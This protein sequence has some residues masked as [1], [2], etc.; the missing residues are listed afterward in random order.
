[1]K[2]ESPVQKKETMEGGFETVENRQEAVEKIRKVISQR[3]EERFGEGGEDEMDFHIPQH[4][5]DVATDTSVFL[6]L[7]REIDPDLVSE[8]DIDLGMLEGLGHDLLQNADKDPGKM[9]RRHRGFEP[10]DVDEDFQKRG[11]VGNERR[12]AN[13][14]IKI[15]KK[16]KYP[17]GSDVFPTDKDEISADIGVTFPWMDFN[18][19]FPEQDDTPVEKR[20]KGLKISQPYLT[21]KSSLRG[22]ALATADL[23][24]DFRFSDDLSVFRKAGKAEYRELKIPIR[25]AI[26]KG[27]ENI[28]PE[29]RAEITKDL[30]SWEASQVGFARWQQILFEKSIEENEM[31]NSSPKAEEIKKVLYK[32]YGK[33]EVN[34]KGADRYYKRLKKEFGKLADA[35][36]QKQLADE[37]GAS[38]RELLREMGYNEV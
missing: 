24:G 2:F 31:L 6:K 34:I 3:L 18:E 33:F 20:K 35:K 5:Y 10:K 22:L 4:S 19:E 7:V 25:D 37:G 16:Y 27:L 26:K 11:V 15:L 13:E 17:D 1:M 32:Q 30:L 28:L 21:H 12:S 14:L 29:Q 23:R 8:E 38:F 9:R 36:E